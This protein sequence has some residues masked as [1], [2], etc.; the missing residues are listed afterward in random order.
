VIT[1]DGT[2]AVTPADQF[3]F[4]PGTEVTGISPA[5][6]PVGGGNTI[7]ITGT[8]FTGTTAVVFQQFVGFHQPHTGR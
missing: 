6:G 5:T 8:G 7:T 3:T 2:S 1:P 4:V